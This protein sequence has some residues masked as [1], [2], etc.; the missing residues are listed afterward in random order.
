TQQD[1]KNFIDANRQKYGISEDKASSL[2]VTD[3]K[4]TEERVKKVGE[5]S[6]HIVN[7]DETFQR[8]PLAQQGYGQDKALL[9]AIAVR[10]GGNNV[11]STNSKK[12]VSG[13]QR[14]THKKGASGLDFL[15]NR[16]NEFRHA[17]V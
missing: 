10:E 3:T 8:T 4:T 1:I 11:W 13:G 9:V 6:E 15:W 12:V 17:G 5:H 2:L 7:S 16:R 14:D